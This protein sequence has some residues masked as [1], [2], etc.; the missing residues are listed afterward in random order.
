[1]ID[2]TDDMTNEEIRDEIE[3]HGYLIGEMLEEA[4]EKLDKQHRAE[5][6]GLGAASEALSAVHEAMQEI[7][8]AD[9]L[10]ERAVSEI[11]IAS[12][13]GD[14]AHD[15]VVEASGVAN[16]SVVDLA[17]ALDLDDDSRPIAEGE[18]TLGGAEYRYRLRI[19]PMEEVDTGAPINHRDPNDE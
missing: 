9:K 17:V 4:E 8:R 15:K 12:D 6:D 18:V 13:L 1:M 5:Q 3:A 2:I 16:Q 19:D 14:V 11:D 10:L 7:E